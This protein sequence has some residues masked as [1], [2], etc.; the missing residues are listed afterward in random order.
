MTCE[1]AATSQVGPTCP[2]LTPFS[3]PLFFLFLLS[4]AGLAGLSFDEGEFGVFGYVTEV[5]CASGLGF[6]WTL[7]LWV[8]FGR[9]MRGSLRGPMFWSYLSCALNRGAQS[10]LSAVSLGRAPL[11]DFPASRAP[12]G[13]T[14]RRQGA[15]ELGR[16]GGGDVL[17]SA[18][19]VSGADKLVR[20]AAADQAAAAASSE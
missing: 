6:A 14:G 8:N 15:D 12:P 5:G 20:P 4:Q 16:L 7:C 17:V 3:P 18:K 11:N 2:P 13:P 9:E 19:L 10:C 1:Q